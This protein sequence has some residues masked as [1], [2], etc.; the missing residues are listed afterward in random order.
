[1]VTVLVQGAVRA[2][3]VADAEVDSSVLIGG[4]IGVIASS[5]AY[6]VLNS[7][8]PKNLL[9]IVGKYDV[10]FNLTELTNSELPP[11]FGAQEEVVPSFLYGNLS[12]GN[13]RKL[14]VPLTTHLFE[15]VN[16]LVVS[17]IVWWMRS[18]FTA[19][20][21]VAQN[22]LNQ[23]YL[24]RDAAVLISFASFL[25]IVLF[26]F[27][28]IACKIGLE[29]KD[30]AVNAEKA[31]FGEWKTLLFWAVIELALLLP[32]FSFGFAVSF[33][34][35]VFG[36]SVAWWVISVGAVGLLLWAGLLTRFSKAKFNLRN[37][38]RIRFDKKYLILILSLIVFMVAVVTLSEHTFNINFKIV[39]P[40]LR[41]FTSVNR[42][43]VFFEFLP[44]FLTY[45]LA[46]GFYLRGF[47]CLSKVRSKFL[48][49]LLSCFKVAFGKVSPFI[50]MLCMQYLPAVLL[51]I[52]LFPSFVGFL[53]DFFWLITPIFFI[54]TA[55]SWWFYRKTGN[56][57]TG[58]VFNSLV[59][60]WV[61]STVFPF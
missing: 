49:G 1:M 21:L 24:Q 39:T 50:F 30:K 8:F 19:E 2:A 59:M 15:P 25:M 41:S 40:I 44:F 52:W 22:N 32:M 35:L 38:F 48:S 53:L 17:E 56:L 51:G 7:S 45:F 6:G 55:C 58:A 10:L 33:P 61:A 46:E 31:V 5:K 27:D 3:F 37:N 60:A 13:A 29:L 36:A 18:S 42:I 9:V 34:P 14:V 43:I 26:A 4:G 54:T 57:W 16:P 11:A 23:T 20:D 47:S 12:F 28:L